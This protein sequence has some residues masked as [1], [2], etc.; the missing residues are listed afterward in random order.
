[1]PTTR[2]DRNKP[3][4]PAFRGPGTIT[5]GRYK[6]RR[7]RKTRNVGHYALVR[8]GPLAAAGIGRVVEVPI[9]DFRLDRYRTSRR[10]RRR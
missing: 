5:A 4:K 3:Y 6:G 1:M 10:N 8:L 7:G 9:S 2:A